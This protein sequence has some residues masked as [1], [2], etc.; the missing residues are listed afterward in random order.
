MPTRQ[1]DG[2]TLADILE[3]EARAGYE[4]EPGECRD[5]DCPDWADRVVDSFWRHFHPESR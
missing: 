2:R 4:P 1:S 3:R 5:P